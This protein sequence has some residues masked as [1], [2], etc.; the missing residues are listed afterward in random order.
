[1]QEFR[2]NLTILVLNFELKAPPGELADL[3]AHQRILK[4]P[5]HCYVRLTAL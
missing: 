4:V 2:I 1:M 3:S 5:R